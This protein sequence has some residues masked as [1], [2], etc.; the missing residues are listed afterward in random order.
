MITLQLN[1]LLNENVNIATGWSFLEII[2]IS[3]MMVPTIPKIT[4]ISSKFWD[5]KLTQPGAKGFTNDALGKFQELSD[6]YL[7]E[8]PNKYAKVDE[9]LNS[10][11]TEIG[12]DPLTGTRI[13]EE[14]DKT[15][16]GNWIVTK[17]GQ[18][19]KVFFTYELPFK[20]FNDKTKTESK[21]YA[22]WE[23]D[24][25]YSDYQLIVQKQS[26]I[27]SDFESKVIYPNTWSP[28]WYNGDN[29]T[30]ASNGFKVNNKK[31]E[32]DKVWTI[33]MKNNN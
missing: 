2:T 25:K 27:N 12:Y 29:V 20:A 6:K 26:G 7:G 9:Y 15:A 3:T 1:T 24:K 4:I 30:I 5:G 10:I 23:K 28:S 13:T 16:F 21:W 11:E 19:S 18:N 31:L 32:K 17:P 22:I 8:A 14:M 33:L